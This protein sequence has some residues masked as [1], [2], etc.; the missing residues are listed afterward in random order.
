MIAIS[1]GHYKEAPGAC[2]NGR[3]EF[4]LATEWAN[5]IY[6]ELRFRT[7]AWIIATGKLPQKVNAVNALNPILAVEIHFNAAGGKGRG[8]ETLYAP[9]SVK[10]K[11]VAELVQHGM[12]QVMRTKDRGVKEGW[13]RMDR[14]GVKDYPGD[15]EGDEQPDYFLRKTKCPAIIIE[16]E[17]IHNYHKYENDVENICSVIA[18]QLMSAAEALKA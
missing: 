13:Y 18:G 9:G 11:Q 7:E 15:V 14:P 6:E 16:P 4:E 8:T 1:I 17:F 5:N 2:W 12:V 10:G 3:C